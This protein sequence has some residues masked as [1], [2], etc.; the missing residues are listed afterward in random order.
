MLG[1]ILNRNS[2]LKKLGKFAL[3][4]AAGLSIDVGLFLIFLTLSWR[5][6]YANLLSAAVA[7]T[8]VY[9]VSTKHVFAYH[10]RFLIHL[11]FVYV[12]YQIL[13][14]T[15]ASWVVDWIVRLGVLPLVSK[16]LML[17]VTFS[18]NYIFMD[19]LTRTKRTRHLAGAGKYRPPITPDQTTIF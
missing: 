18:A 2:E 8:F 16:I 13:A 17:P 5:A 1:A 11:F 3:I 9:F 15:A 7:V 12:V 19:L 4:S 10:G 6:G 14:V